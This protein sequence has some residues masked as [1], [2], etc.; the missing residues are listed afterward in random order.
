[1]PAGSEVVRI[2]GLQARPLNN[3]TSIG[4]VLVRTFRPFWPAGWRI[5]PG[6]LP[7]V[8]RQVEQ[9]VAVIHSLDAAPRRPL[10]LEDI[11]SLSQVANDVHHADPSSNQE[12]V[13]SESWAEYHGICQ[14]MKSR[15]RALS[16]YGPWQKV[17]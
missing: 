4:T 5:F 13:S 2:A 12:R 9:P 14:P 15:Y 16:S 3:G 10:S 1:V 17:A 11:G 8:D 7:P 6:F